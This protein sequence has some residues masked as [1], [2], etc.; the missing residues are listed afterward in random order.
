MCPSI[1]SS[2]R[3]EDDIDVALKEVN[4]VFNE[5]SNSTD[6]VLATLKTEIDQL[7]GNKTY[8]AITIGEPATNNQVVWTAK[9]AGDAGNSIQVIYQYL[10]PA[11]GPPPGTPFVARPTSAVAIGNI[12]YVTLPVKA[13][14]EIDLAQNVNACVITWQA[15]SG[16][17]ALVTLTVVSPGTGAPAPTALLNLAGGK[18]APLKDAEAA[19]NDIAKQLGSNSY[20]ELM[21]GIDVPTIETDADIIQYLESVDDEIVIINKK[22]FLVG[23]T[24]LI[25]LKLLFQ[26]CDSNI[27]KMLSV[28]NQIA[29]TPLLPHVVMT[30]SIPTVTIDMVC[31]NPVTFTTITNTFLAVDEPFATVLKKSVTHDIAA[32]NNYCFWITTTNPDSKSYAKLRSYGIEDGYIADILAGNSPDALDNTEQKPPVVSIIED[33][34][35]FTKLGLTNNEMVELLGKNIDGVKIPTADDS[36]DKQKAL[37]E[38]FKHDNQVLA[39]GMLS[40]IKKPLMVMQAVNVSTTMNDKNLAKELATRGKAC[41][42]L[43]SNFSVGSFKLPNP[44]GLDIP[45]MPSA[46]L[47]DTAKK[48]ESAFGAL[49]SII[50]MA[51]KLFDKQIDGM[52]KICKGMINK[53]QNV[54]SL[55]DNILKNSLIGCLAGA[56]ASTTGMPDYPSPSNPSGNPNN[57]LGGLPLPM[58]LITLALGK[59]SIALDTII[60]KSFESLMSL[61]SYPLCMVQKLLAALTGGIDLGNLLNPCGKGKDPDSN[62]PP[63]KVQSTINLSTDLTSTLSSLPQS[64]NF[65][66][67]AITTDVTESVEA[68]TGAATETIDTT[69][70]SVTRGIKGIMNDLMKGLDSKLELV[71][72]IDKAISALISGTGETSTLASEVEN[73]KSGCSPPALGA[74]NN[75]VIKYI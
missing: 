43:K 16:V 60:T 6:A 27:T 69:V 59:L 51:S 55:V 37:L 25:G 72:Q 5:V 42:R 29:K 8:A 40:R 50:D 23:G 57:A 68:F 24:N 46:D 35:L 67:S 18:D 36:T 1:Y 26:A 33:P 49:A 7:S 17:A 28:L 73:K 53:L 14:G 63:D 3:I 22:L 56:D 38:M 4:R 21:R 47:P 61:I 13:T 52:I 41:A 64:K 9:T 2:C 54:L 31:S 44:P 10:G 70:Q 62:C 32:I 11:G 58:S 12:I 20:T 71:N 39:N 66:T 48:V 30:E 19:A 75:A 65:P 74:I 45:N 34:D 15:G